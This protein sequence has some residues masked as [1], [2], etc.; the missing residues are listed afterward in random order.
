[1][2]NTDLGAAKK[3]KKDAFYTSWVDIEREMNAYLE[4]DPDVFR[5]KTI[6]LPCDD[7]EW[8][9]FTKYFALHFTE[10]GIKKL[11]STSY[12]YDDNAPTGY[13]PPTLFDVPDPADDGS[14]PH[15]RVFIL[16]ADALTGDG[17]VDIDDLTWR[18]LDGDGDFRSPEVTALRDEADMVITNG[19]F[20]LFREF[21]AWL[22]EGGVQFS[23]IGNVNAITYKEV[24]PLIRDNKLWFG[25]SITSGDRE[26]RVPDSYPLQA[27]G[28]RVD[29]DGT[30]YIRV[31]GVRWFTN[32]DHGR[33]HEPMVL[34]STVE[35]VKYS[36]H[37]EVRG[38]GYPRYDNY[39][40]IEVGFTDAIPSDEPGLMGVPITFLDRYNPEQFEI[41]G[42]T[43]T[44]DD[45][46]GLKSRVYPTQTQVAKKTGAT[47]QV[48]KLN[49]GPAIRLPEPPSDETYYLV[50]GEVYVQRY[51]R[52]LIRHR[53][54]A[55]KKD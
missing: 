17:R 49:D 3:A 34:M 32:I 15:G 19:P 21:V 16:E 36:K 5:G 9:N 7:P 48:G 31:K 25:P 1:M 6:L 14:V 44:W 46:R 18:Y 20:S 29:D 30:K 13:E 12:G 47:S 50:D 53:N 8:S 55:P 51:A 4:Y 22:I 41:L 43:K 28:F 11:I 23:I 54:P 24:F 45:A 2:A 42:I 52:I 26:F 27:A 38:I 10:F 37:K 35:N 33:R 39:D 40:A